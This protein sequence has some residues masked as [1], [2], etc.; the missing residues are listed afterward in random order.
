M[1]SE[2]IQRPFTEVVSL[3]RLE[4]PQNLLNDIP[5]V[6]QDTM[7][8]CMLSFHFQ[9]RVHL[10][11]LKARNKFLA[12]GWEWTES[13][14]HMK[15]VVF[16]GYVH[17]LLLPAPELRHS[18]WHIVRERVA[19]MYSASESSLSPR[20]PL[21]ASLI[22]EKQREREKGETAGKERGQERTSASS[23]S[24]VH[25]RSLHLSLHR[26]PPSILP[27]LLL[28]PSSWL[29]FT[30]AEKDVSDGKD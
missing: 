30:P 15:E 21:R 9:P 23:A 22:T 26:L 24:S 14:W 29:V 19:G 12:H 2:H 13:T 3:Y 28:L 11:D 7:T 17:H 20:I 6:P 8:A 5:A 18:F 16:V 4:A 1:S 27:L 25:L 10:N